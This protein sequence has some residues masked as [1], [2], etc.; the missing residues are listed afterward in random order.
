MTLGFCSG[1]SEDLSLKSKYKRISSTFSYFGGMLSI[2]QNCL[3][4]K[5]DYKKE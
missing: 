2:F 5:L 3:F 1:L 4:V